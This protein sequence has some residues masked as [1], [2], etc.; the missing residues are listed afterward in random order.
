MFFELDVAAGLLLSLSFTVLGVAIIRATGFGAAR[1]LECHTRS[2]VSDR[3]SLDSGSRRSLHCGSSRAPSLR[4][5]PILW[6]R[7]LYA[8]SKNA[9]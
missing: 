4:R 2:V 1:R 7:K 3:N 8:L 5:L 6:G 9:W